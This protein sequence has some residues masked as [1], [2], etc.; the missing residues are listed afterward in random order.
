MKSKFIKKMGNKLFKN[1]D[2]KKSYVLAKR[3]HKLMLK[4]F[5]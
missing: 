5:V 4:K 3:Y 1:K 2:E